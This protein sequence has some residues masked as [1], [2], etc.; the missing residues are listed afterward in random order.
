M[1]ALALL[2]FSGGERVG[3]ISGAQTLLSRSRAA[4]RADGGEASA[5][6]DQ[7]LARL[8]EIPE[9]QPALLIAASGGGSRAALL[10]SLVY[11]E[12]RRTPAPAGPGAAPRTLADNV[13]LI[14]SVSGGS[15]ATAYFL[16][17]DDA[18]QGDASARGPHV[19]PATSRFVSSMATDFMAPL[20][21]GVLNLK[22]ERGASVA[23]FWNE[24]FA[25]NGLNDARARA[26][27]RPLV[28]FNAT[29]VQSGARV[30]VGFPAL[31]AGLLRPALV[32]ADVDPQLRIGLADAVR[33]SANFPY[34]F[35]YAVLGD[36]KLAGARSDAVDDQIIDGGVVDNTGLDTLAMI[37]DMLR[38]QASTTQ[39]DAKA[40]A[41]AASYQHALDEMRKRGLLLVEIDA[42]ARPSRPTWPATS[43]S[44]LSKP[45]EALDQAGHR[46]ASILRE[47][48]IDHIR[49]ALDQ[50]EAVPA[51]VGA[52]RA[53]FDCAEGGDVITAWALDHAARAQIYADFASVEDRFANGVAL[54][55]EA[56]GRLHDVRRLDA[57]LGD[58]PLE[59]VKD[60]A[61]SA[62]ELRLL[63]ET[64]L[65]QA[66]GVDAIEH[67]NARDCAA[68]KRDA[69][70]NPTELTLREGIEIARKAEAEAA[71]A[72]RSVASAPGEKPSPAG[73]AAP[74]AGAGQ[75][76]AP[77]AT[78]SVLGWIYIG[79][80]ANGA[81]QTRNAS[82]SGKAKPAVGS[83][84]EL[85][86]TSYVRIS[87]PD[88]RGRLAPIRIALKPHTTLEIMETRDWADTG[89]VWAR[90]ATPAARA[91]NPEMPR[92]SAQP[93]D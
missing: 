37:M 6:I 66:M 24:R 30:C 4:A 57:A 65:E 5:W 61:A 48:N 15:L 56:I 29:G 1:L 13:L 70:R 16:T 47:H 79:N 23:S 3:S 9:T 42:G 64:Y 91:R 93:K 60:P 68:R 35:E 40:Q 89:L 59:G 28:V 34:G 83:V 85:L 69:L 31:P 87:P 78:S 17:Q 82:W 71:R 75:A 72:L 63:Y 11:E 26:V 55:L 21:R 7:L 92:G 50:D 20:L 43:F 52:V 19:D 44:S 51:V 25:W 22:Q 49:E 76:A 36:G 80:L 18:R 33:L 39:G 41:V 84:V 88:K 54:Q 38:R 86:G 8:S 2:V 77:A 81:W 74:E 14:S 10:A 27:N 32:P 53:G 58:V 46:N 62:S 12:L 45:V 73:A 90:V 67:A